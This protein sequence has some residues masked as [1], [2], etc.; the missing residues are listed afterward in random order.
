MNGRTADPEDTLHEA[1]PAQ[2][3]QVT[4]L[5]GVQCARPVLRPG[6]GGQSG[7]GAGESTGPSTSAVWRSLDHPPNMLRAVKPCFQMIEI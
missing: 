6:R 1:G 5:H 4:L 3:P 2:R 7:G